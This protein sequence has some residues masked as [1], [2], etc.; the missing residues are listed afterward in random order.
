MARELC[1]AGKQL[2]EWLKKRDQT[3]T[4]LAEELGIAP[5]V[6]WRWLV[7]ERTPHID[8]AARVE[9]LTGIPAREWMTDEERARL[10]AA[11][12]ETPFAEPDA[13][14]P[15]DSEPRLRHGAPRSAA[16]ER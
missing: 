11:D 3:Q 10:A 9:A 4:W 7:G 8:G 16:G 13:E 1:P 12:T 5:A 15:E 2:I 14:A 6:L